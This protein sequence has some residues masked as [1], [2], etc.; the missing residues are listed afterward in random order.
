[1]DVYICTEETF[2]QYD[3][4]TLYMHHDLIHKPSLVPRRFPESSPL[5]DVRDFI[6]REHF[7]PCNR[8]RLWLFHHRQ[9]KTFRP[10]TLVTDA[11]WAANAYAHGDPPAVCLFVEYTPY[12][13]P[14][15]V[16]SISP[17]DT[18]LLFV[19]YYSPTEAMLRYSGLLHIRRTATI[20]DLRRTIL[21]MALAEGIGLE[22]E[23]LLY[24][25]VHDSLVNAVHPKHTLDQAELINGDVLIVQNDT[26]MLGLNYAPSFITQLQHRT[27][28]RC[29]LQ[30][31]GRC[32]DLLLF[33]AMNDAQ[34]RAKVALAFGVPETVITFCPSSAAHDETALTARH[35]ASVSQPSLHLH[36]PQQHFA[37]L[38]DPA[39]PSSSSSSATAPTAPFSSPGDTASSAATA[40]TTTATIVVSTRRHVDTRQRFP[41]KLQPFLNSETFA[42]CR[43]LLSDGSLIPAHA[44]VL[45]MHSPVLAA[46]LGI[47]NVIYP[48][49]PRPRR[50]ELS[51]YFI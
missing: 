23:F 6:Q 11:G 36:Q 18:I 50:K 1:M 48:S 49:F 16:S 42:D 7:I 41:S 13:L 12:P 21:S 29:V 17:D 9:N 5:S 27:P 51:F 10:D 44:I 26:A 39:L 28:V 25:E 34:V 40:A 30:D 38:S 46:A 31:D 35:I 47:P 2:R 22:E 15:P 33:P 19:K 3:R 20:H 24:E 37:V 4:V 32:A 8:Q 43:V 45:S 14:L